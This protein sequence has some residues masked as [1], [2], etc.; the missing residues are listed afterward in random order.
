MATAPRK[1]RRVKPRRDTPY[2]AALRAASAGL[3]D[4]RAPAMF[5]GGV[6][7]IA[8]GVPRY[9][10]DIDATIA[11]DTREA[12]K[13]ARTMTKHGFAPRTDDAVAFA[14]RSR[15]LLLRHAASGVDLDLSFASLPFEHD[16]LTNA[17]TR[18]YAGVSIRA[19][20]AED[21]LIYK[22]IAHRPQDLEDAE[23]L[24]LLHRTAIDVA[25]VRSVIEEIA[26]ALD[27]VER[28]ATA[29]RL[30]RKGRR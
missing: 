13:L 19:A 10:A 30:L 25:R 7:V 5:I 27:D 12:A 4:A 2:V 16:A 28:A 8:Q 21:L 29:E 6:A 24:V 26:E 18:D 1:A 22:I 15:V 17:E 14:R 23:R 9:T 20:R 11:I 3:K